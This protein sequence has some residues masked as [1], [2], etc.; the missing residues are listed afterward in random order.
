MHQ[1]LCIGHRGAKGHLPENT[2]A[3]FDLAIQQG[4]DWVELDVYCLEGELIVIHDDEVDRTTNGTGMLSDFSL[5]RLRQLDAGNGA[6]VPLLSEVL[7]KVNHRCGINIELKGPDT[8]AP[9]C[10]YLRQVCQQGWQRDEFLLSSF[11]HSELA[12]CDT[13][14]RR[15]ALFGRL[16]PNPF[17]QARALNAWSVNF[18]A[19][20]VG[21]SLVSDAHQEGFKVLVYTVNEAA[22]LARVLAMGVDGIFSDYPDRLR[23]AI[24][25]V[26]KR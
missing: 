26:E 9:V 5:E 20:S 2:L 3:S 12:K 1:T 10:D 21:D 14:F 6:Q 25:S 18:H 23:L 19:K 16:P 13:S 15:G 8:A 22:D 24:D 7:S 17:E 11:D 4:A